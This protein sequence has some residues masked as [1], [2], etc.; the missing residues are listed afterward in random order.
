MLKGDLAAAHAA[1]IGGL[2]IEPYFQ[3]LL[4]CGLHRQFTG[5]KPLGGQ[6]GDGEPLAGAEEKAPQ[7]LVLHLVYLVADFSGVHIP[8]P[9][10]E[11]FDTVKFT[12]V[13]KILQHRNSP[14]SIVD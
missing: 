4:L 5:F 10:P 3:A 7:S 9:E 11:G 8:V 14:F 12:G 13:L 1:G 2:V 6:I